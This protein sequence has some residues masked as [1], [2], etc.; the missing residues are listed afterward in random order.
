MRTPI[1]VLLLMVATFAA[2]QAP[3]QL[4]LMPMPSRVQLGTGH[5]LINQSFSVAVSGYRDGTLERGVQRFVADLSHRTG[6]RLYSTAAKGVAATLVIQAQHG[7][8]SVEKLGEDESYELTISES[9]AKLTATNPLGILH[10]LQTFLQLVETSTDGFSIPAVTIKDQPRFAWR[11]LLIDMRRHYIPVDVLERNIDGMAAVKLNVLH[12]HLSDD[13]GFRV[14]SKRFPKLHEMGSDGLYYTQADIRT[15]VDY[16]RDRG[17]RVIPEFDM[18]AHSRSWFVGYPEL[19]SGPGP[20]QLDD[21]KDPLIDVTRDETYKFLDKFIEEM[22][23]LF[24][25]AYFH[26]GGDEVAGRQW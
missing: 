8:E 10:G 14:E 2:G 17:I 11:A 3:P 13:E 1:A 12:L 20:Y 21:D 15:L 18:P 5:L 16:A 24:P 7:S 19:A 26:I 4:N 23:K 6:M 25:D 9:G 22:A